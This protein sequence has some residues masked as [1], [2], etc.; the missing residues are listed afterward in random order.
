MPRDSTGIVLAGAAALGAYEVG[1]LSYVFETVLADAGTRA[2]DIFCGTSAG[3]INAT[4]VASFADDPRAGVRMLVQAWSE[5]RLSSILRPSAI[6]LLS[7]LVDVA[8]GSRNLRRAL[9]LGS[10]RGGLLDP[11]PIAKVIERIP[12]ARLPGL[13]RSGHLRGLAISATRISD[14][15]AVVFFTARRDV[16]AWTSD[17]NELPTAT[18]IAA[19][20][21]L[22]SA[23][24]PLMFPSV[25]IDGQAYCDGGLRQVVPL[26]PALHPGA[27]RLLVVNPLPAARPAATETR[28]P[29]SP[30]YLAGKA[31]TALFAD[32]VEVDLAQVRRTTAILRAG[33]RRFGPDFERQLG[34]Q[35]VEDGGTALRRVDALCIEPS[36]D[37][38]S[39]AAAYVGGPLFTRRAAG[40]A[41][42]VLR[43]IAD[44]DP[45]RMGDLLAF[46]LFDGGFTSQL[47]ELGRS[48]ARQRHAEISAALLRRS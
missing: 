39:L 1:V 25:A 38:G 37:P 2:P 24:I 16:A 35:L 9:H 34:E 3:A 47:I 13:V 31:L 44:G 17:P 12:A 46:L 41:V 30:L 48:D 5:L 42:R 26:S 32:R 22:A 14:G 20:H 29:S 4:A 6:E 18:P 21:V 45:A 36:I 11:A 7:M 10:A 8:G 43:C 40:P 15:T 33:T 23:A 19:Q 27:D 28:T